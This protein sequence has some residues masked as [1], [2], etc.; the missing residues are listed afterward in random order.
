MTELLMHTCRSALQAITTLRDVLAITAVLVWAASLSPL[1]AVVPP[2]LISQPAC[3]AAA[4]H[5]AG[6]LALAAVL[7]AA[8][9]TAGAVVLSRLR[10]MFL[11]V[12]YDHAH[13]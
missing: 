11:F 4:S 8:A 6:L 12:D 1:F 5:P 2:M 9:L 10:N 13:K 7:L 3:G